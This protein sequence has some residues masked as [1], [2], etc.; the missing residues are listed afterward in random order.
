MEHGN[1]LRLGLMTILSFI[2]MY[3]LMYIMV[4]KFRD[5]YPSFN[6][7]Y[8]AG[9]MTA[10]MI[11]IEL[12]V[13]GSMYKNTIVRSLLI[14]ISTLGLIIFVWL[15]QTQTGITEQ[16]FLRSMIPHH[17]GAVLMCS[18]NENLIDEEV[19]SLCRSII[20]SQQTEIDFMRAKLNKTD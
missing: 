8:M 17:S 3:A 6:Q 10:A 18:K 14:G 7:F 19:K 20:E 9:A 16:D 11:A 2:S 15:T 5:I 13:M 1:W 12:I 4:D